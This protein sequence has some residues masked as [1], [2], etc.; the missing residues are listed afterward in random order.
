[1]ADAPTPSRPPRRL[2]PLTTIAIVALLIGAGV[3]VYK[4]FL[5][6]YHL[7]TVQP[8]VLYRD[9]CQKPSEFVRAIDKVK[10]RTVVSLIDD[11][12]LVDARKPQFKI[13][14]QLLAERGVRL[15]RIPV[16]L[17]G[18]PSKEDVERFLAIT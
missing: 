15:E 16:K 17:G 4:T 5:E 13:E 1:M 14:Q 9:G 7:A 3:F 18:W 6:T 2:R 10:P 12:E 11:A 8:G